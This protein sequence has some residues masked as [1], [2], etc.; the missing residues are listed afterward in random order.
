MI[1]GP[2]EGYATLIMA[3]FMSVWST[4]FLESW[5]ATQARHKMQWGMTGFEDSE[6]DRT[7]FEGRELH[8]P[9]TGLPEKYFPDSEKMWRSVNSYVQIALCMV[10]I[11]TVNAGVFFTYAFLAKY[12]YQNYTS[13]GLPNIFS[14][15]RVVMNLA[16]ALIIQIT[17][18]MFM[19]LAITMNET[20]N[21]RT[22]TQYFDNLIGKVFVFQ[23]VNS[24]GAL[25]YVAMLQSALAY[26][27]GIAEP[28]R[29]RRFDCQPKC[30][31]DVGSLLGT[32]FICRVVLGNIQ[33][34]VL[35]YF[36]MSKRL[37]E[38][39]DGDDDAPDDDE[40]ENPH[41]EQLMRKRQV[42]PVEEQFLKDDYNALSLFNDYSELVIQFGY[43]TLFVSAFP[44]APMFACAA[45][46][47]EIRVDGWKLC[48]VCRRPWPQGAEDIGTW[49]DILTI[50]SI[51]ATI[52]NAVMVT[53][54]SDMFVLM[55]TTTRI[56]VFIALEW[57]LIG[58]KVGLMVSLD[59]VPSDVLMQIERQKFFDEKIVQEKVDEEKDIDEDIN[60][61]IDESAVPIL[62]CDPHIKFRGKDGNAESENDPKRTQQQQEQ[63]EDP[64][65][66]D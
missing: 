40:Y 45:N 35:P 21:H 20:E 57:A 49:E 61:D 60:N 33:E 38:K 36:R 55:S 58:L 54:T 19:P 64:D 3:V 41:D 15:P 47:V 11:S 24:Y 14:V 6:R 16:L 29:M 31:A 26:E 42:S 34:I 9:V 46:F 37:R 48:Q 50:V 63:K 5:K 7:E 1:P 23:F 52:T 28:W 56:L 51:I 30:L 22:E 17:N 10:Y 66:D 53:L 32:I 43:A 62:S 8:S 2:L 18:G 13:F 27:L 4:F 44:L 25:F 65:Q 12:P 39:R 59:S